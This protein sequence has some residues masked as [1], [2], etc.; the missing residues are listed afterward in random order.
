MIRILV[1]FII[2]LGS[3][4]LGIQL[5]YDPGYVLIAINH[6]TIETT[7][8]VTLFGL[9]FLFMILHI[10]LQFCHKIARTPGALSKWNTR[11]LAQKAQA[12]TRKGLI[13]YSEGYWQKAKNH[14]IQALPNTDTPLLNYL[15]AA[16][17]AQ[18]MG[19][20]Q[21]RDHYLRE[22]QQSMPEAKI[23][24]ELTQAQLQLA[25]HQWEQAL[26]TLRHLQDLAPRH[27]YVLKLLM[28]LYEEVRDWPQLIAL[29]P[30]LKKN[31]VISDS[32]FDQLQKNTYQ[33]AIIDLT[34]QHQ[35]EAVS[36]LFNS[37]PKS[38]SYNSEIVTEY[39]RYLYG[40]QDYAQAEALLR[41]CLR[42]EFDSHL[43]ELY[44]LFYNDEHQLSFAES[45]LK[46]NPHSAPLYLCLGRLCM[47]QHLW[48]KAKQYLEQSNE[49]NPTPSAYNELGKLY[50]K[51]ND[52]FLACQSFRKGLALA[53]NKP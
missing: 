35:S 7:L 51:L 5:N 23:A 37:L 46:K 48:G 25:N 40:K 36:N 26:A 10:F 32:A 2:L 14:L 39:V 16:R 22:A 20:S 44:G 28:N 9:L 38:L 3:V 42:K 6:W 27:P 34:K 4:Y 1:A 43:I 33:Q 24:V 12:T 53:I 15:T 47:A 17:A 50:E 41:R 31:H 45:L 19:D 18:K 8:W 30:D 11:R 21:L 52:S 49:L 29:L 13:E